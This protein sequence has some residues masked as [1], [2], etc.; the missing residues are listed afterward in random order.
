MKEIVS[1]KK[2]QIVKQQSEEQEPEKELT[3]WDHLEELRWHIT[4][5]IIAVLSFAILAFVNRTFVFDEIILAPKNAEFISNQLLCKLGLLVGTDALCMN[6]VVLQIINIK[7]PGQFLMHMYISVMMGLVAA[8][9]YVI[10]EVWSFIKP[11][12]YDTEK[13]YSGGAVV[14]MSSLFIVG[15]LF[16]YF[17]IVPL[18]LSFF[19]SYQVSAS[20]I[21][22]IS[23][24]SYVSTVVSLTFAVGIVFELPVFIYFLTKVGVLTPDYLKRNRRWTL[25]VILVVSAIITPSDIFSQVMVSIPLY[26]LYEISIVVSKRVYKKR[27][28]ELDD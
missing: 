7:M 11:A 25:V 16:S 6:D 9:P 5:S 3:F 17:M 12:L 18:T 15:T 8:A 24:S 2:K 26:A 4:R 23:L 10:W 22:Q 1:G 27:M 19:G 21:N 14:V 28:A 20:V 13:K